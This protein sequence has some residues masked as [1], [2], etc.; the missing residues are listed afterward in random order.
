MIP[1]TNSGRRETGF[2]YIK[3]CQTKLLWVFS[4]NEGKSKW[5]SRNATES[6]AINKR[7][8]KANNRATE[9]LRR[10]GKHK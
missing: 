1:K 3:P 7:R 8:N 10:K 6:I 9:N 2:I 5:S 4:P